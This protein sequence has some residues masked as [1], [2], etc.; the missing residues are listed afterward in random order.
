MNSAF[1]ALTRARDFF[2]LERIVPCI[3]DIAGFLK[4]L[5]ALPFV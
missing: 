3:S 2:V 4:A 1:K 5:L